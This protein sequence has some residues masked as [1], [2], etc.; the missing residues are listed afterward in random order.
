MPIEVVNAIKGKRIDFTWLL[1]ETWQF[2]INPKDSL[3]VLLDLTNVVFTGGIHNK[4]IYAPTNPMIALAENNGIMVDRLAKIVTISKDII[5]PPTFFVPKDL[6]LYY[7]IRMLFPNQVRS[8]LIY[9]LGV[10]TLTV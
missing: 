8:G 9:G 2:Q 10:L 3:G 6:T 1:G 4:N 5:L 7:S